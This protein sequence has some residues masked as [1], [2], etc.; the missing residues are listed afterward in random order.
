MSNQAQGPFSDV[1]SLKEHVAQQCDVLGYVVVQDSPAANCT[2][3]SL[4]INRKGVNVAVQVKNHKART[5]IA[6]VCKF[7]E[8]LD[9]ASS[10]HFHNG[11]LISTSGFSKPALTHVRTERPSNLW[12]GTC[13]PYGIRWDYD[14][15]NLDE[16]DSGEQPSPPTSVIDDRGV[17]YI[18]VFTC[19]GGVGKTT[20]AAH[21]A[22][23]FALQGYDVILVD[24]DPDRNLRKL[25]IEDQSADD[26]TASLY[27]PAHRKGFIG[28]TITVLNAE[29]WDEHAY[30]EIKV[31]ICD[32]SPVLSEN[33]ARFVRRFDYC[34]IPTTLNPLG[35]A[36]NGDVI[37]RTFRHIRE[38]N[39]KADL[40][41]LINCYNDDG[42]FVRRNRLL[43]TALDQTISAYRKED[44]NCQ[45]IHPLDAKIRRND[46]LLYWG[47]HIVDGTKPR[48]A[49]NEILGRSVP[50]TDFLQLAEYLENR[51]SIKDQKPS[52][53]RSGSNTDATTTTATQIAV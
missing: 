24:L 48:L 4:E 43:L 50:R 41:V 40:L 29:E 39:R 27:V 53:D 13:T 44:P 18:G 36:K 11:W 17:T 52:A 35:I 12:L 2:T 34:L 45:L 28:S 6:Q 5:N 20:V 26:E 47:F 33:P 23:A 1:A 14:P 46:N 9:L 7:T 3:H 31:V 37:T 21:L 38:A 49:F 19:K 10:S 22:G 8:F 16:P 51:T 15:N 32:C 30:P 42:S 25:F